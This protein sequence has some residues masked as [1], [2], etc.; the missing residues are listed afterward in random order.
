MDLSGKMS[1][2]GKKETKTKGLRATGSVK[3]FLRSTTTSKKGIRCFSVLGGIFAVLLICTS[4]MLLS[5]FPLSDSNNFHEKML[6]GTWVRKMEKNG[7]K[8]TET[9]FITDDGSKYTCNFLEDKKVKHFILTKLESYYFISIKRQAEKEDSSWMIFRLQ[10]KDNKMLVLGL[11]EEGLKLA[12]KIQETRDKKIHMKISQS[13]LQQ[14]CVRNADLFTMEIYCYERKSDTHDTT[15]RQSESVSM[16]ANELCSLMMN[17]EAKF[18]KD[19]PTTAALKAHGQELINTS[20]EMFS[21]ISKARIPTDV[22]DS[23]LELAQNY[24]EMGHL[25]ANAPY[26]PQDAAEGFFYGLLRGAAGDYTGGYG[27]ISTWQEK[28]K[29][30]INEFN[31]KKQKFVVTLIKNGVEL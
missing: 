5:N 19:N 24:G 6:E 29:Q 9:V 14:W 20:N 28:I 18:P 22:R 27:E 1:D 12:E 10:F 21:M 17:V 30:K 2:N 15:G 16:F 7:K 31:E 8:Q 25:L 23:A 26:I 4:C 13:E 3:A 11:N